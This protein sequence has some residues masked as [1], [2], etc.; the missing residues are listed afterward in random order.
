MSPVLDPGTRTAWHGD[1]LGAIALAPRSI[2]ELL[3]RAERHRQRWLDG[4][5]QEHGRPM[6]ERIEH[7]MARAEQELTDVVLY[8]ATYRDE[9]GNRIDPESVVQGK[10]TEHVTEYR[11]RA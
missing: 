9:H 11:P 3:A 4:I 7:A 1:D 2:D 8:G 10:V 5:E 6:R